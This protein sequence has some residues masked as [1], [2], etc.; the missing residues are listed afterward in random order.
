MTENKDDEEAKEIE[1]IEQG[2]DINNKN[3]DEEE[4]NKESE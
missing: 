1:I 3:A 2:N 4:D